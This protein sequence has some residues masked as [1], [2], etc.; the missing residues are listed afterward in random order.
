VRFKAEGPGSM[1]AAARPAR[2]VEVKVRK[3]GG[4]HASH[5]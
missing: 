4:G 5:H 1:P 2:D 3:P